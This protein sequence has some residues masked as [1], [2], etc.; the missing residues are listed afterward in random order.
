MIVFDGHNDTLSRL[1]W[2]EDADA[3]AFLRESDGGAID[4]PRARRSGFGG[5][6]FAIFADAPEDSPE[7]DPL[8][9]T[10]FTEDGYITSHRSPIVQADAAAYTDAL[11]DLAQ[12]IEAESRGDVEIVTTTGDLVRCLDS[13]VLAM[14]LHLEGAEA[15]HED[16]SNLETY[17]AAGIRSIG[18]VWSRPNVF[19]DGVPFRFPG[20]PDTGD[21]LTD[22]GV[23]LVRACNDL[24]I[25]VDAAHLNERG[26]WDVA[27]LSRAPLVVTHA[28][29]H[30]ITPS[31]RNLTDAQIDAVA[32]SGGLIGINF[33]AMSTHPYS[34]VD[35]DVPLAQITRHIEYIA[36]RVGVEHVAFGSDFDGAEMPYMLSDVRGLPDLLGEL[37][38]HGFDI[39]SLEKIAY[40]NWLR[41][42]QATWA[43]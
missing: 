23:A 30:A 2:L 3:S 18:L 6:L 22:A 32:A 25:M 36:N 20:T 38:A 26:F 9:G 10:E 8:Y 41:V 37:H 33:E 24:G 14:V 21:G 29:V 15:I 4:V 11:I 7:R 39:P 40:R 16:L 43:D 19:G 5:G 1:Y 13:G 12:R 28:D 42:F 31:T 17:Y 34:D 27:E 35:R